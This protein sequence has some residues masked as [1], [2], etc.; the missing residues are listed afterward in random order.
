[1]TTS[2]QLPTL[3]CIL[4]T[5]LAA[6]GGALP[7]QG[8]DQASPPATLPAATSAPASPAG[9]P[10]CFVGF[11]DD[12]GV[13]RQDLPI[14]VT[15]VDAFADGHG[16]S[17]GAGVQ[18][19]LM[20]FVQGQ[21]MSASASAHL[22]IT[23]ASGPFALVRSVDLTQR[24]SGAYGTF[25]AF[26]F[27]TRA[28]PEGQYQASATLDG[29]ILA[30]SNLLSITV[31]RTPPSVE[32][33]IEG[34]PAGDQPLPADFT[35]TAVVGAHTAGSLQLADVTVS[36]IGPAVAKPLPSAKPSWA[37]FATTVDSGSLPGSVA[38]VEALIDGAQ[39]QPDTAGSNPD[40]DHVVLRATV[41]DVL[42]NS[43]SAEVGLPVAAVGV[44][45]H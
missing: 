3:R 21:M 23:T 14:T 25:F 8:P 29:N 32:L 18:P 33:T 45:Q 43:S 42:G 44:G 20:V 16:L 19:T 27:D 41:T 22:E 34:L 31:D 12:Q 30:G 38:T 4:L 37:S 1:M 5:L 35:V 26:P 11:G 28:L 13:C 39:I 24:Q 7:T 2:T 17:V 36:A 15:G 6:C 40:P 9:K 10:S